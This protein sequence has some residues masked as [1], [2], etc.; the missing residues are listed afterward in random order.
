MTSAFAP[1]SLFRPLLS[2]G[3]AQPG[4]SPWQGF[5]R[6]LV[7]GTPIGLKPMQLLGRR[8]VPAVPIK[9]AVQVTGAQVASPV[10]SVASPKARLVRVVRVRE[11]GQSRASAGRMV[12]SGRMADVC[13][14]LDRL[15]AQEGAPN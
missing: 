3:H 4:S 14:E 6:W 2:F 1:A 5:C 7:D 9:G 12:I 13:A 8:S 15:A 11:S 10:C